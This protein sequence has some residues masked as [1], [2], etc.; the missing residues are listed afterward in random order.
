MVFVVG[1]YAEGVDR[2]VEKDDKSAWIY[3]SIE[4]KFWF[5]SAIMWDSRLVL[6]GDRD[7]RLDNIDTSDKYIFKFEIWALYM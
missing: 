6:I 4:P 5:I 7:N 3:C 1:G 2:F